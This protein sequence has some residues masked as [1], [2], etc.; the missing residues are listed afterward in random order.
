MRQ[1]DK[2]ADRAIEVEA[3][4]SSRIAV[5]KLSSRAVVRGLQFANCS[6]RFRSEA[7]TFFKS[8]SPIDVHIDLCAFAARFRLARHPFISRRTRVRL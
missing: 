1:N 8:A 6:S 4:C 3:N 7:A 2:Q 5:S